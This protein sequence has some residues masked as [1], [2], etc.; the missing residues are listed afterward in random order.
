MFDGGLVQAFPGHAVDRAVLVA[1]LVPSPT[2]AFYGRPMAVW[3]VG[4]YEQKE[5]SI[6][7]LLANELT[8][9]FGKE[10]DAV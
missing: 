8:G 2:R 1:R 3:A 9:P 5:R 7:F 10:I 4:R 6:P